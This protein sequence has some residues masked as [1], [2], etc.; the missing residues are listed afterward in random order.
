[1]MD[2]CSPTG[3]RTFL[4]GGITPRS[5]PIS[6]RH[7]LLKAQGGILSKRVLARCSRLPVATSKWWRSPIPTPRFV[8][9]VLVWFWFCP[10]L[11]NE[12]VVEGWICVVRLRTYTLRRPVG[13]M[14]I[15][16]AVH[17]G[18]ARTAPL[19]AAVAARVRL[20]LLPRRRAPPQHYPVAT[21]VL[22]AIGLCRI[23]TYLLQ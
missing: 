23:W 7:R 12:P 17:H 5:L 3:S 16:T 22:W 19:P 18:C 14:I 20:L 9:F 4:K 21:T 1:M 6:F 2:M 13:R 11:C 10:P 8:P 15:K